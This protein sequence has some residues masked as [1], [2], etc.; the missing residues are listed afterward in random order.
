MIANPANVLI[1]I[2]KPF[3]QLEVGDY[4]YGDQM[5]SIPPVNANFTIS[6]GAKFIQLSGNQIINVGVC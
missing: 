4:V 2:A 1:Y 5:L 3:E 6:N